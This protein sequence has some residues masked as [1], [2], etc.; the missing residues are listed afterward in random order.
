MAYIFSLFMVYLSI[1][2]DLEWSLSTGASRV[3]MPLTLLFSFFGLLQIYCMKE[4]ISQ[5]T[6]QME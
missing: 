5:K 3:I 2:Y 4:K 1:P 6:F